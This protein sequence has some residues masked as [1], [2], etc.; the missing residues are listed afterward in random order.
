MLFSLRVSEGEL[1]RPKN[2]GDTMNTN[3]V[4]SLSRDQGNSLI[5]GVLLPHSGTLAH[6]S[7]TLSPDSAVRKGFLVEVIMFVSC[8]VPC[9][10][11]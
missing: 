5:F 8:K 2:G 6:H 7:V 10:R 11:V 4:V 1:Q 3:N 9:L